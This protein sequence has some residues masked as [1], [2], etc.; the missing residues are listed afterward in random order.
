MVCDHP[1]SGNYHPPPCKIAS[2]T[3]TRASR[4]PLRNMTTLFLRS[5]LP[6]VRGARALETATLRLP[7][8][9]YRNITVEILALCDNNFAP[10]HTSQPAR[11][12]GVGEFTVNLP[13]SARYVRFR[14]LFTM[15]GQPM[16]SYCY[17]PSSTEP[18]WKNAD[19]LRLRAALL[20]ASRF[21][22]D[23]SGVDHTS[24]KQQAGPC[25]SG[26]AMAIVHAAI[27]EAINSISPHSVSQFG[28]IEASGSLEAAIA[29]ASHDT[30]IWLFSLQ[31]ADINAELVANLATIRNG[32]SKTNGIAA[33]AA[34]AAAVIANRSGDNGNSY[35]EETWNDYKTR[36]YGVGAIPLPEWKQDPVS[37]IDAAVGS[38]WADVVPPFTLLAPSQFV[39]AAEPI[40]TGPEFAL[41]LQQIA[42]LGGDPNAP[43]NPPQTEPTATVRSEDA[44]EAGIWWCFDGQ[45]LIG[46]P[47][48]LYF[49]IACQLATVQPLPTWE[50][51][52]LLAILSVG[53]A[54]A[55]IAAW[56]WKY[57][58]KLARP[59]T[60]ARDVTTNPNFT[61]VPEWTPLGAPRTNTM[62]PA[63]TP[64]FPGLPSGHS[65]FGSVL[66]E[67]LRNFL[68]TDDI[69]FTFVS[70]EYD[71]NF[72]PYRPRSFIRLSQAEEENGISRIYI[73]VHVT[74]DQ[75]EGKQLGHNVANWV[76]GQWW[77]SL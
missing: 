67:L 5:G 8:V 56:Y 55:G 21:A 1:C 37:L 51:A 41:Q 22:N 24:N 45:P 26:R 29:Q 52:R 30:L 46:S 39:V 53:M 65:T 35:V 14:M 77:Q 63:F 72:R 6:V 36:V 32:S 70:E 15:D 9:L 48:R 27:Y 31:T 74:C 33:G 2:P 23:R 59:V 62:L 19:D 40:Y 75:S 10:V 69:P 43:S 7:G 42:C 57:Q 38:Q 17:E 18:I 34:A 20:R 64:P 49:Q 13:E 73:G 28:V 61:A 4:H 66:F 58:H 76:D 47:I 68:G 71:G 12:N 3:K 25:K 50:F 44:T 60:L 16:E 11:T 54:D